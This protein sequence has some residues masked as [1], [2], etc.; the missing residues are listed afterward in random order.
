MAGK[1]KSIL[2]FWNAESQTLRDRNTIHYHLKEK[3]V[4]IHLKIFGSLFE[5]NTKVSEPG[6]FLGKL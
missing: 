3:N 4:L 6:C 5:V 2:A 1:F